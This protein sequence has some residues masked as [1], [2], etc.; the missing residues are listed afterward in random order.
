MIALFESV[1]PKEIYLSDFEEFVRDSQLE[2]TFEEDQATI[3]V[4]TIHKAKGHEFD[5]VYLYLDNVEDKTDEEK[6]RLFVGMTRAK[7]S[8]RIHYSGSLFDEI[9]D[10]SI[11]RVDDVKTYDQPNEIVLSLTLAD[12]YLDFVAGKKSIL[13]Q[14]RSGQRL[15]F[16]DKTFYGQL[17][18]KDYP[19]AYLSKACQ[20]KIQKQRDLGY[21]PVRAEIN[22]IVA[23]VN[24]TKDETEAVVLPNLYF[25]RLY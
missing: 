7:N 24:Q 14:F 18:G 12:V 5:T 1:T 23:W 19:C 10:K 11:I 2:D 17:N 9:N 4:S 6:R 16:K 21:I 8:L 22:F 25:V 15:T 20:L 3:F 13:C